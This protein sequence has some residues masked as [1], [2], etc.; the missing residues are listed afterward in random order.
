M[1][2]SRMPSSRRQLSMSQPVIATAPRSRASGR[3]T[4][5]VRGRRRS[6]QNGAECS[7]RRSPVRAGTDDERGGAHRVDVLRVAGEAP[8]EV[9][10]EAALW[11]AEAGAYGEGGA[12]VLE[13]DA[14]GLVCA[15]VGSEVGSEVVVAQGGAKSERA[16][17]D[18]AGAAAADDAGLGSD[19][20]PGLQLGIEVGVRRDTVAARVGA[21]PVL[22]SEGACAYVDAG[23]S[24][25]ATSREFGRRNIRIA[26]PRPTMR[27][28]RV[29]RPCSCSTCVE[30]SAAG[31]AMGQ[32]RDA[33]CAFRSA[34]LTSTRSRE[35]IV[36][37]ASST[38]MGA[39]SG[40]GWS[41]SGEETESPHA[42]A[43]LCRNGASADIPGW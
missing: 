15:E 40:I 20:E 23:G 19:C 24:D 21:R 25:T 5:L 16:M 26:W 37:R 2:H 34:A 31:V 41:I 3:C 30:A 11:V 38:T 9:E 39:R 32:R 10:E 28:V 13:G 1:P 42:G 4:R 7:G 35:V 33:C 17:P 12:E 6:G 29:C 18:A 27:P 8:L 22:E 36:S 14:R 43:R